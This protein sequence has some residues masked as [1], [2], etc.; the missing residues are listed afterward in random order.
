MKFGDLFLIDIGLSVDSALVSE[1]LSKKKVSKTVTLLCLK[2]LG[3]NR[4]SRKIIMTL[5]LIFLLTV[6]NFLL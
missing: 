6:S 5:Y 4:N 3:I 2:I 1:L